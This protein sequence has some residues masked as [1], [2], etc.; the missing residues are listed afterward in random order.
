MANTGG[1]KLIVLGV[2]RELACIAMV[3]GFAI[4]RGTECDTVCCFWSL[5]PLTR[6]QQS[7]NNLHR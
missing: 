1:R 5:Q 2:L 6:A 4:V 7:T 3:F